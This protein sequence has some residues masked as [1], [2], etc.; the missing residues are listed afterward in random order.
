MKD[1]AVDAAKDAVEG[2]C[3]ADKLKGDA[4]DAAKGAAKGAAEKKC[5]EGKCGGK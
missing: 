5:G 1:K 4:V 2:K 3:G